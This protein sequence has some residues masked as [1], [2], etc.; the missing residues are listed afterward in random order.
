M[1]RSKRWGRGGL[2]PPTRSPTAPTLRGPLRGA[3]PL[4]PLKGANELSID[5]E[6]GAP[7]PYPQTL[8]APAGSSPTGAPAGSRALRGAAGASHVNC[9]EKLTFEMRSR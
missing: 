2:R 6:W 3:A 8:G 5:G 9:R 1:V 7:P 4:G